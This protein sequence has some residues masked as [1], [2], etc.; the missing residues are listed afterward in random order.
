M[1]MGWQKSGFWNTG[2]GYRSSSRLQSHPVLGAQCCSTLP[3][4]F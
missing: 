3:C 1:L 4:R 2:S